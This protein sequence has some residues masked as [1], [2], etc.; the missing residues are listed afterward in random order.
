MEERGLT[1]SES[2][3]RSRRD[4]SNDVEKHED[5]ELRILEGVLGLLPV[6]FGSTSSVSRSRSVGENSSLGDLFLRRGEPGNYGKA[7]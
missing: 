1:S 3:K 2:S 6:P 4:G 5:V 7:E